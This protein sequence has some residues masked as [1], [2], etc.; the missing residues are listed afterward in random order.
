MTML[1]DYI[2]M[3]LRRWWLVLLPV[4]ALT[5]V[6]VATFRA[7]SPGYTVT[8][9]YAAGLPPEQTSNAFDYDRYY[10]W[11]SS[12]YMANGFA[13]IARTSLFAQNVAD[14]VNAQGMSVSPGQLQGSISSDQKQSIM[15]IYL[16]WPDAAQ[17]VKIGDAISAEFAEHGATYWP[18]ISAA[19][20]APVV[21][22]D[23]PVAVPGAISLRDRFD[24]P[25]RFIVALVCGLA[26]ALIAHF[27]DPYVRERQE[28]ERMGLH[29]IVEIPLT[30]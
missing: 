10:T 21:P 26:L 18:Q 24:L 5:I 28:L 8:L 9:R 22:L 16:N 27:L 3:I 6:T 12:E 4:A 14:R 19:T 1:N 2:R 13:D 11:L 7:P 25:M 23:K 15:V 17:A 20:S 29:I 30:K